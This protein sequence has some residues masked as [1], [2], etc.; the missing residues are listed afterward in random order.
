MGG[1]SDGENIFDVATLGMYSIRAE[2]LSN[3]DI[4]FRSAF[5]YIRCS[6]PYLTIL[7]SIHYKPEISSQ[8]TAL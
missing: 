2:L 8:S 1:C 7:Y 6:T 4:M 5:Y 3:I